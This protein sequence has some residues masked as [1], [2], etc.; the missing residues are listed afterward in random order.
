MFH[1]PKP[2][3]VVQASMEAPALSDLIQ[4]AQESSRMLS[5]VRQ[6]IPQGLQSQITAG[7]WDRNQWC[8]L[9]NNSS[10]AT[11]MRHL[12]P[13][14]EAHLRTQGWAVQSMRFKVLKT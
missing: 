13:A 4:L 12:Q 6:L 9:V 7:P 8:I 14:L 11:K 1:K 5:A 3:P 2:K 10:A